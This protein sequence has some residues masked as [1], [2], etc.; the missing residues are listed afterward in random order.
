MILQGIISIIVM[1]LC[2]SLLHYKSSGKYLL[3]GNHA[4]YCFKKKMYIK[5]CI[6]GSIYC[7]TVARMSHFFMFTIRVLMLF[8]WYIYLML[9]PCCL[10]FPLSSSILLPLQVQ[11]IKMN[12]NDWKR[13]KGGE[14]FL[15]KK[16]GETRNK[17]YRSACS[18]FV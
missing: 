3:V 1:H 2:M 14:E 12:K 5:K 13:E 6:H 8:L 4:L 17:I 10:H 15:M 16:R 7:S 9:C 11:Y 18:S